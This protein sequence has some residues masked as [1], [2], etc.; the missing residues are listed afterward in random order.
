MST[1]MQGR[2][3]VMTGATSGIGQVA[4]ERLAAMGARI[5]QVARDP[6][7]GEA[8]LARLHALAPGAAHTIHYADLLRLS[9]MKRV[10]AEIAGAEPRVDVLVNNAGALF[11]SFALVEGLERTFA[12]NHMAYFVLAAALGA[13]L[14]APARVVNTASDA[15]QAGFL[16]LDDLQSARL[17]GRHGPGSWLRHGGPGFGVYAR[18][19]LCNILFTRELA[20]RL[21]GTGVTANSLHPGFVATRF[22]DQAG[23]VL[24]FGVRIAKR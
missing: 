20:R 7:R 21:A 3:V 9:E 23:G 12:L 15:H 19:K 16:D 11:G 18:S 13:R 10:A 1:D 5:V 8:A 17:Y 22:G 14:A 6:R 24:S 4:A 2:V